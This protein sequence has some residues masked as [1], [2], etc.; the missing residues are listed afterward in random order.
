MSW[1]NSE[2]SDQ[3]ELYKRLNFKDADKWYMH[4]PESVLENETNE[5]LWDFEIQMDHPILVR[6][7]DQVLINEKERACH[8]FQQTTEW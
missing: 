2:K 4:K 3:L 5:I 8:L 6:K 7:P 1:Q